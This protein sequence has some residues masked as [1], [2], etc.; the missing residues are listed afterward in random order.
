LQI[1]QLLAARSK[2]RNALLA[3]ALFEYLDPQ[4]CIL[5]LLR[6]RFQLLLQ[7]CVDLGEEGL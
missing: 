4:L 6:C 1:R 7:L 5:E 2:L 3:Q